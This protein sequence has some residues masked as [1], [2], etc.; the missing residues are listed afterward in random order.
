M[1]DAVKLYIA[2]AKV[3][4]ISQLEYPMSYFLRTASKIILW[5][6]G[7]AT[8]AIVLGR[9][10]SMGGWDLYQVLFIYAMNHLAYA[11]GA[12]FINNAFDKLSRNI[13]AG[14]FDSILT[15]PVNPLTYFICMHV[16]AGYTSNY[17]LGIG[18]MIYSIVKM[19]IRF[20]IGDILLLIFMVLCA[21][22]LMGSLFAFFS[23][24]QFWLLRNTSLKRLFFSDMK[25]F[26]NYPISIYTK[27]IQFV[28][29]FVMPYAFIS[30]YPTT[31]L[32][33]PGGALFSPALAY[34]TPVIAVIVALLTYGFWLLGINSYQSTGS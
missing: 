28:L 31:L 11:I 3:T 21:S 5:V 30:Y 33:N 4:F 34:G 23:I 16:S 24:P 8:I 9:F 13:M 32:F 14:E 10:R 20:T 1:L 2:F 19:N 27:G 7:F 22:L 6:S 25:D 12:T 18:V 26:V 17:A 15:K 29:T